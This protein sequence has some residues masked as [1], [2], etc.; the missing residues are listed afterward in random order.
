MDYAQKI[1]KEK[2]YTLIRTSCETIEGMIYKRPDN[3]MLDSIN[4]G[5]GDFIA[6]SDVKVYSGVDGRF[7]YETDF[8][9]VNK[10]H[11][12]LITQKSTSIS[13]DINS[14]KQEPKK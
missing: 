14:A 9:A 12:V 2:V 11:I 1:T 8:M 5:S 3:R 6:V 10:N 4:I 13:D 7:L